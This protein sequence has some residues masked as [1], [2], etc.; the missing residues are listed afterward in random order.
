MGRVRVAGLDFTTDYL[1]SE[2]AAFQHLM[3]RDRWMNQETLESRRA[4]VKGLTFVMLN[5]R[6]DADETAWELFHQVMDAY[7]DLCD[8]RRITY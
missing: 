5:L 6:G 7:Y 4:A 3:Q 2:I 8:H 1:R